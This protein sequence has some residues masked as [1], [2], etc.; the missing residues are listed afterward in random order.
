M[1]SVCREVNILV[2]IRTSSILSCKTSL[3]ADDIVML[4]QVSTDALSRHVNYLW[5]DTKAAALTPAE[6]LV[7]RSNLLGADQCIT[8]TG[9]GNT[10]TKLSELSPVT[11]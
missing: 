2:G 10:S 3:V 4:M 9:G 6:L 5:D 8:N 7:Y 1:V 11:G